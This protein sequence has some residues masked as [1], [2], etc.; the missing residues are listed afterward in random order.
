MITYI[1]IA[2]ITISIAYILLRQTE[3]KKSLFLLIS[4]VLLSAVSLYFYLGKPDYSDQPYATLKAKE[5]ELRQLSTDELIATY[6]KALEK[7]DSAQARMAIANVLARL[8]R[9]SEAL[10]H[11]KKAY[12]LDNQKTPD[13]IISYA[14]ILIALKDRQVS[15]EGL[16]LVQKALEIQQDNPRGLFYQ[17]LYYAQHDNKDKAKQIWRSLVET[18]QD[19]PW[20]ATTIDNLSQI[21][22]D[23][24]ITLAELG[25]S[26]MPTENRAITKDDLSM[27]AS[28]VK[29]LEQKVIANPDDKK[30][31]QQLER[32][33]K[34]FERIKKTVK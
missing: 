1:L 13:I 34:E 21:I 5:K 17:G 11:Y 2:G 28:M 8:G 23:Y 7:N 6:I 9:F 15:E 27:I 24:N 26:D 3:Q 30:L 31:T 22:P 33:K 12:E 19:K 32:V 20:Q 16:A 18:S 25:L 10:P 29:R 4:C 14:E